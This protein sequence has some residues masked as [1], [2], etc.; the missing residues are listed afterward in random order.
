MEELQVAHSLA[1]VGV[2]DLYFTHLVWV[3]KEW[4][5]NAYRF[6]R[7]YADQLGP[8]RSEDLSRNASG[9]NCAAI[10]M[11]LEIISTGR[12]AEKHS[13]QYSGD[14]TDGR[15][16]WDRKPFDQIMEVG[17]KV[18]LELLEEKSL[19]QVFRCVLY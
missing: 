14:R 13:G 12:V 6:S 3:K 11:L 1:R 7:F 19:L 16:A 5:A 9:V 2:A 10:V 4:E 18:L 15:L 8:D 17:G